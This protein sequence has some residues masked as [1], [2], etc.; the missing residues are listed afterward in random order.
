[1]FLVKPP[2]RSASAWVSASTTS[3]SRSR[4]TG[5]VHLRPADVWLNRHQ[6]F[7]TDRPLHSFIEVLRIGGRGYHRLYEQL[8]SVLSRPFARFFG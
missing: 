2:G 7:E 1:M 6:D 5:P 4:S 3:T 8:P